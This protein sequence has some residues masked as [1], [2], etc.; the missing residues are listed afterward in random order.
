MIFNAL[1]VSHLRRP[2]RRRGKDL[3]REVSGHAGYRDGG[4]DSTPWE[5]L[6]YTRDV[7]SLMKGYDIERT[8]MALF[9]DLFKSFERITSSHQNPCGRPP[10]WRGLWLPSLAYPFATLCGMP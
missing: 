5:Y 1:A 6:P 9:A 7:M 4:R 2:R 8:D 3:H 10:R